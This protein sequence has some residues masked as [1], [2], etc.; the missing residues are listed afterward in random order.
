MSTFQTNPI[1]WSYSTSPFSHFTMSCKCQ[2][3]F[4]QRDSEIRCFAS[5]GFKSVMMYRSNCAMIDWWLYYFVRFII[6][7][8]YSSCCTNTCVLQILPYFSLYN[9]RF[10]PFKIQ[11]RRGNMFNNWMRQQTWF[12]RI[13]LCCCFFPEQQVVICFRTFAFSTEQRISLF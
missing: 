6:R 12:V 7:S 5:S 2:H 3:H 9:I 1:W 11:A 13:R 4:S 8:G 10:H